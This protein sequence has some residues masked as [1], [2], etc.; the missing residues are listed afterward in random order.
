MKLLKISFLWVFCL[1]NQW[2]LAQNDT[3]IYRLVEQPPQYPE[4]QAAMFKYLSQNIKY[5]ETC[6]ENGTES[7][8]YLNFIIEKNGSIKNVT[9]IRGC[10][11]KEWMELNIKMLQNMPKWKAG[12]HDDKA[13]RVAYTLPIKIHLE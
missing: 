3:T 1:S 7:T 11:C 4:G 6:R 8:M 10:G 5:P 12:R 9:C 2:V 13:V